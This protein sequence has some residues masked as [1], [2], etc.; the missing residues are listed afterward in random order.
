MGRLQTDAGILKHKGKIPEWAEDDV[1]RRINRF[2]NDKGHNHLDK[3]TLIGR[4]G[5]KKT[6]EFE[7]EKETHH[8]YSVYL[9]W[10]PDRGTVMLAYNYIT[11]E[12]QAV[13]ENPYVAETHCMHN[14]SCK[15]KWDRYDDGR[16]TWKLLMATHRGF[17][18]IQASNQQMAE[19]LEEEFGDDE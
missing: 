12:S 18:T 15:N 7:D 8:F 4:D 11:P 16:K 9:N 17:H 6:T 19:E 10:G 5:G 13:G 14:D 3:I 2:L 1:K